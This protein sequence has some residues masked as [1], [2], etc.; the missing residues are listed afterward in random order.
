MN[1]RVLQVIGGVMFVYMAWVLTTLSNSIQADRA[2]I[3]TLVDR[4]STLEGKNE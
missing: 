4:V 3:Y 1:D 2:V